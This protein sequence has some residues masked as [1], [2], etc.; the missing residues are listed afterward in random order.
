MVRDTSFNQPHRMRGLFHQSAVD[1]FPKMEVERLY[2]I[3]TNQ[4][5]LRSDNYICLSDGLSYDVSPENIGK[6]CILPSSYAGRPQYIHER[7]LNTMA[8]I[9]HFG[10]TSLLSHATPNGQ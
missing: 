6:A 5:R 10:I 2:F 9:R 3:K 1:A 7:A 8:Y 4:T